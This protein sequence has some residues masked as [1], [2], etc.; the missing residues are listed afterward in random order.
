MHT[1]KV[2]PLKASLHLP[3]GPTLRRCQQSHEQLPGRHPRVLARSNVQGAACLLSA[4]TPPER[5]RAHLRADAHRSLP[6]AGGR[7]WLVDHLIPKEQ[8]TTQ[9]KRTRG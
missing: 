9:E 1:G 7:N 5:L 8:A 6:P 4:L 2:P 3:A